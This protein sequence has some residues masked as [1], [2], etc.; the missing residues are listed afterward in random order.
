M[1]Y[2]PARL[3]TPSSNHGFRSEA[4]HVKTCALGPLCW[5]FGAKTPSPARPARARC[6]KST[7][8][9][10]GENRE[11]VKFTDT[12]CRRASKSGTASDGVAAATFYV[13]RRHLSIGNGQDPT[14]VVPP[15]LPSNSNPRQIPVGEFLDVA[16]LSEHTADPGR[17]RR[18][19]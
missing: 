7:L 12:P 17:V 18:F 3:Y 8:Q 2:P 13:C 16:P 11:R 19:A 4:A 9:R 15:F 6:G 10:T 1:T 14:N 5:L